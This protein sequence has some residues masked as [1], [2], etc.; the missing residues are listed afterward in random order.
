MVKQPSSETED[1]SSGEKKT[2]GD[3]ETKVYTC[4]HCAKSFSRSQQLGGH[5]SKAHPGQS[6]RYNDKL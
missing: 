4:E 5:Q 2:N 1:K 6:Q 3:A